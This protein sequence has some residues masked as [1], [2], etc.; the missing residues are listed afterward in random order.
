LNAR[1]LAVRVTELAAVMPDVLG[2]MAP[3]SPER[4]TRRRV[5][6]NVVIVAGL[7]ASVVAIATYVV[8]PENIARD[9]PAIASS[10]GFNTKPS[11]AVNGRIYEQFG[12]HSNAEASPWLRID[13]EKAYDL[14]RIRV[15]GRHDCCFEQSIPIAVELSNDGQNFTSLA[16]RDTPFDQLDPWEIVPETPVRARFLR[17]R[18]LK[19]P[20][21]VL[22]EVEAYGKVPR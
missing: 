9:K 15:F 12:F 10:V 6:R 5:V 8:R 18:A 20:L 14:T 2:L 3:R 7:L 16:E 11:G 4:A 22:T 17:V 21:L 1:E 13:L 19:T